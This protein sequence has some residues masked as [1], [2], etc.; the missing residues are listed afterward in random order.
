MVLAGAVVIMIFGFLAMFSSSNA[1]KDRSG[2]Q[3]QAESRPTGDASRDRPEPGLRDSVACRRYQQ[4]GQQRRPGQP[5]GRKG[6]RANANERSTQ[7]PE[8]ARERATYGDPA[9]E[10]Y[11]QAK[12]GYRGPAAAHCGRKRPS[13]SSASRASCRNE[14]DALKKSSLVFVRNNSAT[15]DATIR[16]ASLTSEPALLERKAAGLLPERQPAG[17]AAAVRSKHGGQVAGGCRDRIQL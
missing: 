13:A 17:G 1:T 16:P 3:E 4:P 8:D 15:S 5:G 7:D 11:R 12:A 2:R 14:A 9:L 10:A 6:H